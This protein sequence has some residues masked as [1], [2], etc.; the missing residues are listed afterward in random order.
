MSNGRNHK[1]KKPK[2]AF[3]RAALSLTAGLSSEAADN[4]TDMVKEVATEYGYNDSVMIRRL[5]SRLRQAA[6]SKSKPWAKE[7]LTRLE[8]ASA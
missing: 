4:L 8:G 3:E 6:R 7:V 2:T 5:Q 1:T